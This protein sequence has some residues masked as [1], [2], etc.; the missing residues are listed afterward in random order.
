MNLISNTLERTLSLRINNYLIEITAPKAEESS[1][2]V[3]LYNDVESSDQSAET[4]AI[5]P[6]VIAALKKAAEFVLAL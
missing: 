5:P 4:V 1:Y 6:Q 3:S 2:I